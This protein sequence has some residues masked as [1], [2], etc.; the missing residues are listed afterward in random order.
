MASQR[1]TRTEAPAQRIIDFGQ[2]HVR[3][4]DFYEYGVLNL[5]EAENSVHR[6]NVKDLTCSCRDEKFRREEGEACKHLAYTLFQAPSKMDLEA[7]VFQRATDEFERLTRAVQ[8]LEQ[9]STVVESEAAAG[10]SANG[11]Q[12]AASSK[13][14][15]IDNP[16]ER[17]ESLLRDAGLDPDDFELF[18]DSQFGSLQIDQDGY[19]DDGEFETWVELSDDLEL[20]Y[21]GDSDVNYLE[22]SRFPEVLG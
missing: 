11:S 7:E 5:K 1:D 4:I 9:T 14:E 17:M 15:S 20:G 16:V 13:Q 8:E 12:A 18:V 10:A 3:Q 2:L 22:E 21:D 6:V 19:L